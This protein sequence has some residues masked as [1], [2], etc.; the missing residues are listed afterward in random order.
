MDLWI[1]VTLSAAFFQTLRFMLHKVLST[2]A[3]S[4]TGSTFARFAYASPGALLVV[5]GYLVW[6]GQDWP[7]LTPAFW[8][9]AMMWALGQILAT[10]CVVMLFQQRN[11][12]VGIT[13]K[14]T[15]V[16]QTALVGLAILGEN[17]SAA[18]WGAILVGGTTGGFG[19]IG[20]VTSGLGALLSGGIIGA[21]AGAG[22]GLLFHAIVK[23]AN[24]LSDVDVSV[25]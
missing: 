16:I 15:E 3:L 18:G 17:L 8:A 2:G 7:H 13:F 25:F 24:Q 5:G 12:A 11:F 20:G 14:K 10:I 23:P 9:Y 21:I 4:S 1:A 6:T 19:L 22:C